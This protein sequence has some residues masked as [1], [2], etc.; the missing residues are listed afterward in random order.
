M[1]RW[2]ISVISLGLLGLASA[3][4][5]L[6]HDDEWLGYFAVHEGQRYDFGMRAAKGEMWMIPR[7]RDRDQVA[8]LNRLKIQYGIEEV[9]PGGATVFKEIDMSSM[10][11]EQAATKDLERQVVRGKA[12]GGAE[13][14]LVIE[15]ARDVVSLG[16]KVV[17]AGK[18]TKYPLRFVL[19]V[20]IPNVYR[21]VDSAVK[22]NKRA[23]E[24]RIRGDYV[25]LKRLDGSQKKLEAGDSDPMNGEEISGQGIEQME[26]RISYFE[27]RRFYFQSSKNAVLTVTD[28]GLAKPWYE[29][30]TLQW[31]PDAAA[32]KDGRAR[33][34]F[35]VK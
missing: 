35:C 34:S 22:D 19:R 14:E 2:I 3:E 9:L 32:D 20:V 12:T 1:K 30:M 11:S 5:P 7:Q 8:E 25:E 16:G 21:T 23:F 33:L 6:L 24:K 18:L 31:L 17:S 27:G 26:M 4:L 29:G 10:S 28:G 15:Q 13:F